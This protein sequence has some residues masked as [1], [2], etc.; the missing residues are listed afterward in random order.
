[1]IT[2]R[3][4]RLLQAVHDSELLFNE[5][6]TLVTPLN[7]GPRVLLPAIASVLAAFVVIPLVDLHLI[8]GIVCLSGSCL[9]L[10]KIRQVS[11]KKLMPIGRFRVPWR[12]LRDRDSH[13]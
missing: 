8:E 1:M 13:L 6:W 2:C 10:K 12:F 11:L 7:P 4:C 5:L 9:Y 3:L